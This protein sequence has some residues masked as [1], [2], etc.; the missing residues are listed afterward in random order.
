V[1]Q[2]EPV[3]GPRNAYVKKPPLL[4]QLF[5]VVQRTAV[6][7]H[8]LFQP[9]DEDDREFQP[10]GGVQGQQRGGTGRFFDVVG[11]RHQG[12]LLQ[13]FAQTHV[14][15]QGGDVAQLHH[16]VPAVLPFVGAIVDVFPIAG[17]LQNEVEQFGDGGAVA[18][19]GPG[20]KQFAKVLQG[21]EGTAVKAMLRQGIGCQLQHRFA[22]L[23][24]VLRRPF[25]Q[26]LQRFSSN[27]PRGHVDDAAKAD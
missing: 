1:Q 15:A 27:A 8:L 4:G 23:P 10:F 25:L 12:D 21:G 6:R 11:F 20:V 7:Q 24:A 22:R 5:R 9:G 3:F 2:I 13:K 19:G 14:A 17:L 26:L 16:V 18:D